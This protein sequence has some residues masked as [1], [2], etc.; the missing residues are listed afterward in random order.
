MKGQTWVNLCWALRT[1][2]MFFMGVVPAILLFVYILVMMPLAAVLPG[3]VT[4]LA[5]IAVLALL[6]TDPTVEGPLPAVVLQG[7]GTSTPCAFGV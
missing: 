3:L 5:G 1:T 2:L 7:F 4:W 6:G